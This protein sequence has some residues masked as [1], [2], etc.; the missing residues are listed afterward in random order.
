MKVNLLID[1]KNSK[2]GYENIPL[3]QQSID[4]VPDSACKE[5]MADNVLEFVTKEVLQILIKKIRRGGTLEIRSPESQ[6]ICRQY[7]IGAL[8]FD[9]T[10]DLLTGGRVRLTTLSQ[11]RELLEGA[12]FQVQFAGINGPFYR[13]T[14]TR[15]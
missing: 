2:D 1:E 8:D 10:S 12:G 9:E 5:M 11:T 14:A 4:S 15:Q 3:Q 6:E 7:Q 13:I